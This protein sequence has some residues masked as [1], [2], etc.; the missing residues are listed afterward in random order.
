MET[1]NTTPCHTVEFNEFKNMPRVRDLTFV[2]R[3]GDLVVIRSRGTMRLAKVTKVGRIR[4]A[5][6]YTTEGALR[7]AARYGS[8]PVIT[9]KSVAMDDDFLRFAERPTR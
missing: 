2:L 7:D 6:E 8:R 4:I 5:T 9:R 3:S 1:T